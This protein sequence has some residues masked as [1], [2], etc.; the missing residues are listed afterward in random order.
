MGVPVVITP[1]RKSTI[2]DVQGHEFQEGYDGMLSG[3]HGE[4]TIRAWERL[5]Q[6]GCTMCNGPIFRRDHEEI[7]WIGEY[8]NQPLCLQCLEW[9]TTMDEERANGYLKD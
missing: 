1:K 3:P 2:L 6:D 9:S 4:V 8:N 5:V 7:T